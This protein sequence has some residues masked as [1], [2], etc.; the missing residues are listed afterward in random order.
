MQREGDTGFVEPRP[1]GIEVGIG[2]RPASLRTGA[3]MDDARALG[4]HPVELLA[5]LVDV[6]Q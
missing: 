4:E 2:W 1:E 6:E 5:G 3:E